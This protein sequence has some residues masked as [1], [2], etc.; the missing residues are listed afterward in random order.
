MITV[1]GCLF[2]L[3][4]D[5]C[6]DESATCTQGCVNT[7]GSFV[8]SCSPGFQLGTDGESC[9]RKLPLTNFF[10]FKIIIY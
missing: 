1:L 3:D 6:A 10:G 5:E 9:Y 8:C 7:L 4:I 2:V